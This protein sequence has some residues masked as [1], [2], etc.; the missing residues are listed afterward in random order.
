M[1][2]IGKNLCPY[3]GQPIERQGNMQDG[4]LA[5][6][7]SQAPHADRNVDR[8]LEREYFDVTKMMKPR[9][10]KAIK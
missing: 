9:A 4:M 5:Y 10:K 7:Q 1:P 2:E 8:R 3:C 6:F